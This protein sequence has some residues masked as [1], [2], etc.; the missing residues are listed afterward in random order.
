MAL[1]APDKKHSPE[2]KKARMRTE[3][4]HLIQRKRDNYQE[5]YGIN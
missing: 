4:G 2:M 3:K 5:E 1:L